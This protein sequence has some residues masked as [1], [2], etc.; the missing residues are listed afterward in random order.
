L[1]INAVIVEDATPD[2]IELARIDENLLH[3]PLTPS[4]E[5]KALLRRKQI[6][7]KIFP[8][9]KRGG[10]RRSIASKSQ[11]GRPKNFAAATAAATGRSERS[12]NRATARG[13]NIADSVLSKVSGSKLD[14]GAFLDELAVLGPDEQE[15][16]VEERMALTDGP[17]ALTSEAAIQ[18]DLRRLNAAWAAASAQAR[19]RF[20]SQ[21]RMDVAHV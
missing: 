15:Q 13:E 1:E 19:A 6:F 5:A 8:Q 17:E 12:I 20:I 9:A 7:Q 16:M 10:D 21:I 14:N 18:N 11:V 4:A 2:Q 3:R